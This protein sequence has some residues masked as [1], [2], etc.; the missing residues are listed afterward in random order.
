M[1]KHQLRDEEA[2][3]A[4]ALLREMRDAVKLYFMPITAVISAVG[5]A[6][7]VEERRRKVLDRKFARR[8]YNARTPS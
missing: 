8:R 7:D 3:T 2:A 1:S 6:V 4:H 5:K